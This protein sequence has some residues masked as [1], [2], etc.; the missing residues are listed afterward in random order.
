MEPLIESA[1]VPTALADVALVCLIQLTATPEG[2]SYSFSKFYFIYLDAIIKSVSFAK[3]IELLEL[4]QNPDILLKV[5][6][7]SIFSSN[8]FS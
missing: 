6:K 5:L 2:R 7:V 8:S 4:Q 1:I 3:L